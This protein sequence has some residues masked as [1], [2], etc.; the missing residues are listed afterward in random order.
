MDAI[1]K[2]W[3]EVFGKLV[4]Q[5][6]GAKHPTAAFRKIEELGRHLIMGRE[7]YRALAKEAVNK[8]P[9]TLR[10]METRSSFPVPMGMI[11]SVELAW[12]EA[13]DAV[14]RFA[15]LA[16]KLVGVEEVDVRLTGGLRHVLAK[17]SK[18]CNT[19]LPRLPVGWWRKA[20]RFHTFAEAVYLMLGTPTC[21]D[22]SYLLKE[23]EVALG[24][25]ADREGK[26]V[27]VR[28]APV[29]AGIRPSI[30]HKIRLSSRYGKFVNDP[31]SAI[32]RVGANALG[33]AAVAAMID[34][35]TRKGPGRYAVKL[36]KAKGER[37][38]RSGRKA[39]R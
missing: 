8:A 16:G 19:H 25:V 3:L 2:M 20:N 14:V 28:V 33:A 34:K 27:G 24:L 22:L 12:H 39:L 23:L 38:S 10:Y 15:S 29:P 17:I 31:D 9:P 35:V 6:R 18:G 21:P 1:K 7:I 11:K 5:V 4:A 36:A 30:I 26:R 37:R 32:V 13:E